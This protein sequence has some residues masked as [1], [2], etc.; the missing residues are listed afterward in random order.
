MET[1]KIVA[2]KLGNEEYGLDID[3]VQSIERIQH[4]TRVPNAPSYVQG[5]IN[6]RGN[7]TPIIDLRS[8]LNIGEVS[9]TEQTR[10]IITKYE[11]IELGFSVDQTSDVIDITA[12]MIEPAFESELDND[13]F[14]GI[15]K[16]EER[17]IIFLK[18]TE[19]IKATT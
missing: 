15:A 16:I 4:I 1:M 17:L 5:V 13:F 10:V 6:L 7:V 19:L 14:G 9:F 11:E 3:Y 2:F 18:L 12:E 8:K